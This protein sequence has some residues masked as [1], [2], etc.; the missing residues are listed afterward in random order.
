MSKIT[1]C[2]NGNTVERFCTWVTLVRDPQ[3]N[4]IG[5]ADYSAT[6]KS[7]DFVGEIMVGNNGGKS[8]NG[9]RKRNAN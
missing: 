1:K 8:Q 4:Q 2:Q 5:E 6:P 9:T 7:A 3:G